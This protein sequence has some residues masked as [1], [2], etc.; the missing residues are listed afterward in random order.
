[1]ELKGKITIFPE[2][3]EREND[4]GEVESFIVCRGTI[5]SKSE[6]GEYINKSVNVKFAGDKF[7]K[8]KVNQLDPEKCYSLE[9]EKGFLSVNEMT[10]AHGTR[11]ELEIVVL[12]G[13]L[14]G[15]KV[16]ERPVVKEETKDGDLPF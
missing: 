2:L 12:E 8:A 1:M 11:K 3:K 14:T 9:I 16:V 10:N 4:K 6:S 13:K 15:S 5:S 7:P